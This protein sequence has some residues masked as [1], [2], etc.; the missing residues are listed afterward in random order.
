MTAMQRLASF[1]SRAAWVFE[2]DFDTDQ[3]IG[4]ANLKVQ[5]EEAL[6][7]LAMTRF[8]R[9]FRRDVRPGD[10]LV[11]G[12]NFGYGHPHAVG[13]KAM[14][15]LG[16]RAVV[17]ESFFPSYWINEIG[18]GFLQIVCPGI[19][20]AVQR[21]DDLDIDFES[22]HIRVVRTGQVLPIKPYSD[23]DVDI[24]LAGGLTK[25]LMSNRASNRQMLAS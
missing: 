7:Q 2:D 14:R 11:G 5:D 13:M 9:D 24:L 10:M 3:I 12:K 8:D 17:A 19:A 6:A 16:I 25:L 21:W 4:V 23:R 15:K 1:R 20:A 18:C 22:R